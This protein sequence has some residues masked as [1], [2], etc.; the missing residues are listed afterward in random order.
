MH[1]PFPIPP[2]PW[3]SQLVQPVADYA[4]LPTLPLHIHEILISF[5]GYTWINK[6]VAPRLSKYL[7]PVRYP[8]LSAEKKLN[9]DVHVVSLFQS[10]L[11]NAWALWVMW[12]DEERAAMDW[13]QRIWGYTGASGMIQALAQGYF[14]WDLMI[15]VQ[16]IRVFGIGMLAHALSSLTVFSLGFVSLAYISKKW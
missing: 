10:T 16:H 4:N 8:A 13:Q 1:D 3:L 5:I 9:W 7:F 12:A 15:T 11:I 6:W 2:I 14:V